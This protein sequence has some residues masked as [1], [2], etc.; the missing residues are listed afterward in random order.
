VAYAHAI[1][2]MQENDV[3]LTAI[4]DEY[5]LQIPS[6]YSAVNHHGIGMGCTAEVDV[7]CIEGKWYMGL[8][9][10]ND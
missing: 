5:F 10:L 3:C 1:E 4:I 9:C 7:S 2:G 8:L 6:C